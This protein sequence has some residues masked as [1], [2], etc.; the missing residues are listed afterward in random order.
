MTER[1]FVRL[2]R[3]TEDRPDELDERVWESEVSMTEGDSNVSWD[4]RDESPIVIGDFTL[5]GLRIDLSTSKIR[6]DQDFC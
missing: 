4:A 3:K 1:L 5:R 2:Y 6:G